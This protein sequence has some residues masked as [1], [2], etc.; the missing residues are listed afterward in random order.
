MMQQHTHNVLR[1][2][3]RLRPLPALLHPARM[4]TAPLHASYHLA[5][6]HCTAS[7]PHCRPRLLQPASPLQVCQHSLTQMHIGLLM[8]LLLLHQGSRCCGCWTTPR[9][10]MPVQTLPRAKLHS[11][12]TP[13]RSPLSCTPWTSAHQGSSTC[14]VP[15]AQAS[16]YSTTPVSPPR[17]AHRWCHSTQLI[18]CR[19]C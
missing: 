2:L 15:C 10:H 3:T 14:S 16:T 4:C 19:C 8:P 1:Y 7:G 13:F 9:R 11:N 5:S 12:T 6:T 17:S 18:W